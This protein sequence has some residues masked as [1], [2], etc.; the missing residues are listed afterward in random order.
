MSVYPKRVETFLKEVYEK[1]PKMRRH[2]D[3]RMFYL[4]TSYPKVQESIILMSNQ[5]IPDDYGSD[6]MVSIINS[7]AKTFGFVEGVLMKPDDFQKHI[8]TPIDDSIKELRGS[9]FKTCAYEVW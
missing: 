8:V 5:W 9:E 2:P 1:H 6:N 3:Y 7:L 4:Y